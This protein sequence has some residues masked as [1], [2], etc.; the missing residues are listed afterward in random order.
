MPIKPAPTPPCDHQNVQHFLREAR[1]CVSIVYTKCA[2]AGS[3]GQSRGVAAHSLWES[4]L[5]DS[6]DR[7]TTEGGSEKWQ[8]TRSKE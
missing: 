3:T 8:I 7:K 6:H 5:D 1:S 2:V 4:P